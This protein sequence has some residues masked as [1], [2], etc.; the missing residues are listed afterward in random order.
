LDSNIR[1]IFTYC[2]LYT[3]P[4][5][6]HPAGARDYFLFVY[7]D[8]PAAGGHTLQCASAE[9]SCEARHA[10]TMNDEWWVLDDRGTPAAVGRFVASHVG[11][12]L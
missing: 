4:A 1:W 2:H 8:E 5:G 6:S 12:Q 11:A 10:A 7:D 3:H 9:W